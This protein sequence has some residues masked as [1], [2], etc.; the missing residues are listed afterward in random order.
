MLSVGHRALSR[1]F[2][3]RATST[4]DFAGGFAAVPPPLLAAVPPNANNE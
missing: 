2:V 3:T 1:A 4:C